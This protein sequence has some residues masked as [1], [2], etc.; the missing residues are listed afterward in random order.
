MMKVIKFLTALTALFTPFISSA[1]SSIPSGHGPIGVMGEHLHAPGE[2]MFSYRN[3]RME[4]EESRIG[5]QRIT[6]SE[7]VGTAENPGQFAVAPTEMT[8]DMHMFGAMYGLNNRVTLVGVLMYVDKRMDHITRAGGAFTTRS[9]GIGDSKVGALVGLHKSENHTFLAGLMASLP[10]GS[11]DERDD[12]PVMEDAFLPYP[13]QLGSGTFDFNPSIVYRGQN[14][15]RSWSW[16]SQ[17][18]AI[19]RSGTNDEGYTLGDQFSA[20]GWLA[21]DFNHNLSLSLRLSYRDLDVIDGANPALNPLMIQTADPL[22][23]GGERVDFS[24]GA[25]YIFE[26]GHRLA[27]E[28]AEP[29]SQDLN[30][31][32]L[33]SES[34]LTVGWQ[35]VF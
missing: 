5:S 23:Q 35:K 17:V 26:S 6:A 13:M 31:P 2:L 28:Y 34:M 12:T 4:M 10:T 18:A 14:A 25:N 1:D 16:G 24:I 8:T 15:S 22:L 21:R 27:I 11:I 3:M 7:I 29:I 32:Q 9:S 30:G 33:Q 19:I 20:N